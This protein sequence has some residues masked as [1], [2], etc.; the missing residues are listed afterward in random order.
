VTKRESG[1]DALLGPVQLRLGDTG[2]SSIVFPQVGDVGS[3]HAAFTERGASPSHIERVNWI[4]M[5]MFEVR[6]PD[7]NILW[8][9]QSYHKQPENPS[10][11]KGQSSGMRQA[12]PELPVSRVAAAVEYYRDVLGFKINYQQEDLG[13]MDRDAIT[14]LLI[15]RTKHHQG[16]GSFEVYVEDADAL[17][18]ELRA[19]GAQIE[20]PPVN[21]AW[22]LREFRVF[23]PDGNRITLAQTFE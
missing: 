12:L 14:I 4:K 19:K 10:H 18:D 5:R 13:V 6:D 15:E 3:L 11:R 16:I 9:G 1:A 17:Y 7:A 8:F 21:R 22:G 20:G 2:E 23:D